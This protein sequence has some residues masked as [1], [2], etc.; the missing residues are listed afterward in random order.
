MSCTPIPGAE[1]GMASA[2]APA[3]LAIVAKWV[4]AKNVGRRSPSTSTSSP[5]PTGGGGAGEEQ[6]DAAELYKAAV[7]EKVKGGM[8]EF[9]AIQ[10]VNRER[11]E[12]YRAM[13]QP[14]GGK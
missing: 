2:G 5:T 6:R 11:P 12:L 4:S 13:Q 7:F 10:A 14:K 9:A 3:T 1:Q 8:S